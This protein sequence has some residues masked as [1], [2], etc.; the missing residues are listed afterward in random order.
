MAK[1][2]EVSFKP[3]DLGSAWKKVVV[4]RTNQYFAF[5]GLIQNV[6]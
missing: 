1:T 6:S 2:I 4:Y 5:N 3:V